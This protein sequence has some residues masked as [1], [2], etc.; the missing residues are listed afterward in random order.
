[1][2][3]Q[4]RK[5]SDNEDMNIDIDVTDRQLNQDDQME[6][7]LKEA[8]SQKN[9]NT[10]PILRGKS[11]ELASISHKPLLLNIWIFLIVTT[12]FSLNSNYVLSQLNQMKELLTVK[13]NWVEDS[14]E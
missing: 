7:F 12:M 9:G 8:A 5:Q 14:P 2:L 10:T 11:A 3:A 1:M 6:V 4:N 13:F